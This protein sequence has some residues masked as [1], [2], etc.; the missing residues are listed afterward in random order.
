MPS[1]TT[2]FVAVP[3]AVLSAAFVRKL[4]GQMFGYSASDSEKAKA[5]IEGV[6]YMFMMASSVASIAV[7]KYASFNPTF[8]FGFGFGGAL[9]LLDANI[10][11]WCYM[12]E[13]VK[14]TL[15]G[16]S[17]LGLGLTAWHFS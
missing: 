4:S 5:S 7:A 16:A 17:V 1:Y 12:P 9:T 14:T 13:A 11:Y 10:E 6:R 3:L 15:L 2:W 8:S